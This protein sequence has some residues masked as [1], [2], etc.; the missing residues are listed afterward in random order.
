M[1]PRDMSDRQRTLLR[2]NTGPAILAHD[3]NE[4]S[5]SNSVG[6]REP[7]E[8]ALNFASFIGIDDFKVSSWR[9]FSLRLGLVGVYLV[10]GMM[11]G[12]YQGWPLPFSLYFTMQTLTTV[13]YGDFAFHH[14]P[15]N[16]LLLA[17]LFVLLGVFVMGF[18]MSAIFDKAYESMGALLVKRRQGQE[19]CHGNGGF[20]EPRTAEQTRSDLSCALYHLRRRLLSCVSVLVVLL[21]LGSSAVSII[22]GWDWRKS[23]YWACVTFTSTGYGDVVPLDGRSRM[24]VMIL[25]LFG[26]IALGSCAGFIV[27][28]FAF[29]REARLREKVF[30]QF[31]TELTSEELAVLTSPQERRE[32]GLNS[33]D[34]SITRAEFSLLMLVKLGRVNKDELIATQRAFDALDVDGSGSLNNKDVEI[35]ETIRQLRQQRTSSH[36]PVRCA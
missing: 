18:A 20:T 6:I 33:S 9:W 25:M 11:I 32:L 14:S 16:F 1:A 30:T 7:T 35:H 23:F 5:E 29:V 27:S 26:V 22:E 24:L 34:Q 15:P 2:G 3:L 21:V 28:Y 4:T 13:G 31:G 36:S 12:S 8:A 17:G 19:A 10:L